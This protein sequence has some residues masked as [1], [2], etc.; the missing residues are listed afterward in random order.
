[1]GQ[2]LSFQQELLRI[3][4][5]TNRIEYSK[6]QGRTWATR[7]HFTTQMGVLQ[8]LAVQGTTL[9]AMTTKGLYVSTNQG[10]TFT[11]RN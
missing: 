5:T 9:L 7:C 10:R 6:N 2:L 8:D 4:P 11:K 1:M 3:Q